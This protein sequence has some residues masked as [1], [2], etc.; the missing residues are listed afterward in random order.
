MGNDSGDQKGEDHIRSEPVE[1]ADGLSDDPLI[2]H[3]GKVIIDATAC[4]QDIAYPTDPDLLS[5]AR[6]KS[7]ELTDLLYDRL[8]HGQKPRTYRQSARREYLETAQRRKKTKKQIRPAIRKQLSYPGCNICSIHGLLDACGRISLTK[9]ELKYFY[10]I[11]T[12]YDQ[13]LL[14]YRTRTHPEMKF[15][16]NNYGNFISKALKISDCFLENRA[17]MIHLM[18]L[19]AM[20]SI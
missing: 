3:K 11:R 6:Q 7:E 4:P 10:V 20:F 19:F 18:Q 14:M 2:T 5:D 16:V 13:Q 12:L 1:Q 9:R 8:L 15:P 17:N